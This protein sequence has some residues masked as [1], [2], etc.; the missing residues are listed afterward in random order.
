MTIATNEEK[1]SDSIF[2]GANDNASGVS[3][4]ISLAKYYASLNDNERS[5]LF[6]AF[7]GEEL[8]TLGSKHFAQLLNP[9]SIIAVINFDMIGRSCNQ[10]KRPYITGSQYSSIK[11]TFNTALL[12]YDKKKYGKNYFV[13]DEFEK[14]HLFFRSDNISFAKKGIPAHTVMCSSPQD[15]YYHQLKDE[16]I[17]LDY[18]LIAET[19]KSIAIA[20]SSLVNGS[21]TPARLKFKIINKNLFL[22]LK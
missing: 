18:S 8:G 20:C 3:A 6:I 19:A 13:E 21:Y 22:E 15:K 12:S 9:D 10:K 17:T 14:E 2:N 11:Q 1:A 5:I 4:I 7:T 16:A